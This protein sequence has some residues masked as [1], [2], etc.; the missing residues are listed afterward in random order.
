MA[1]SGKTA[2]LGHCRRCGLTWMATGLAH[3]AGCCRSFTSVGLFDRHRVAVLTS[4]TP[5]LNPAE[6]MD[7]GEPAMIRRDDGVWR[8]PILSE[9]AKA[10]LK[11]SR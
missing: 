11:G 7:K 4:G 3:C 1:E 6:L 5:C 9:E 2:P 10:R 8:G